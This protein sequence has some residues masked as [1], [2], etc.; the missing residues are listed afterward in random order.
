LHYVSTFFSFFLFS[1]G[2]RAR[3]CGTGGGFAPWAARPSSEFRSGPVGSSAL[4]GLAGEPGG[5]HGGGRSTAMENGGAA[6]RSDPSESLLPSSGLTQTL[7]QSRWGVAPAASARTGSC[8]L[9]CPA[10]FLLPPDLNCPAGPFCFPSQSSS[11]VRVVLPVTGVFPPCQTVY[12]FNARAPLSAWG[13]IREISRGHWGAG[14]AYHLSGPVWS[15]AILAPSGP[16]NHLGVAPL[17]EL[18]GAGRT[19]PGRSSNAW[20]RAKFDPT[21]TRPR[22]LGTH[23]TRTTLW[24][25][26]HQDCRAGVSPPPGAGAL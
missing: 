19:P 20:Q 18:G 14:L 8:A 12:T 5:P 9:T 11:A 4:C 16:L 23:K 15:T 24:N 3:T 7:S 6:A 1:R 10:D 13:L 17:T 2:A 22:P 25:L 21:S 26:V